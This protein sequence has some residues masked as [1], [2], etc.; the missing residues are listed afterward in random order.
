MFLFSF[1][2]EKSACELG[3]LSAQECS[4]CVSLVVL[5]KMSACRAEELCSGVV[6][7]FSLGSYL[8][9]FVHDLIV[10]DYVNVACA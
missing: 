10:C 5:T 2:T 3:E 1:L 7:E 9:T 6:N 8:V 4:F